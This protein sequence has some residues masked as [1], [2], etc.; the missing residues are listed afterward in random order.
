MRL[1]KL[2][3]LPAFA[4]VALFCFCSLLAPAEEG[5]W[6][7]DNPPTKLLQ[8]KYGFMPTQEWLDHVRLSCARL[9]DGGS[10]SFVSPDGLLLTNHHVARGQLQKS[11]NPEHDYIANGFYAATLDQE[12][13]SPDL[14][15]NVLQSME[16]VTR[17]VQGAVKPGMTDADALKARQAQIAAI[18]NESM[19]ATGLRSDV[20]S[21]YQGGEYWLYRYKKYT[22]VRIVFAP[23]QQAA[24]F[25]GDP[26]NFTYPRYDLDMAIFRVY[27]N[28]KPLHTENYLKVNTKGASENELVFVA[29][30]P[31]ETMRDYTVAQLEQARDLSEPEVLAL[32][33]HRLLVMKNYAAQ[34]PEQARQASSSIFGLANEVKALEGR[35]D[36]LRDKQVF[37]KKI[38]EE[39]D[40]R[41]KVSARPEWSREF[42]GA[43]P[44]I[45]RAVERDAKFYKPSLFRRLDSVMGNMA[46]NL[47]RYAAETS[48]P[49]GER[50]KGFHESQ[51]DSLKYMLLSRAPIYPEMEIARTT[52]SLQQAQEELGPNDP[53][54]KIVLEGRTPAEAA[55]YYIGGS[56]LADQ[57]VRKQLLEGGEPAIEAST[58][59]LIALVRKVDPLSRALY[60]Q[61]DDEVTAIETK[62]GEKIGKARFLVYGKN[63][64]P[65]ATFTLR[66]SYG[67]AVG[68]PMNG[69][70][71]PYK[72]TYYGLYDR[73][74]SFDNQFPFD[75]PKRYVEGKDKL[76][77]TTPLDFVMTCDIIGGNSGSP[78][79][80]RNAEL[81]GVIFDGNIESLVGDFVYD[82]TRNRAVGVHSAA[83]IE[84]LRKLYGADKLADELEGK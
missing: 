45:E 61:V 53:W 34:G 81:V 33:R 55:K 26:D 18:E 67:T 21:L 72:T 56:K 79:I 80:N 70:K 2:A 9:N 27:E 76:D 3:C 43:W 64:Y 28:G 68:Y 66:L 19:K 40:F 17:R 57:A 10:G 35:L 6:T 14:E 36:G 75:L 24:F 16:E 77:L 47:V 71:A 30:H 7:F 11:S 44:E 5:M 82:G 62:D 4:G 63:S 38:S 49:D 39:A 25:G 15:V 22:D 69:T 52:G 20:I 51:L 78:V 58:D 60:K 12:I 13:K 50:L 31:G 73:S 8:Q 46:I 42:A 65:D 41:Q 37:A 1:L 23:E 32:F 48:K 29:G 54:L 83:M 74:A 84:A 59:P